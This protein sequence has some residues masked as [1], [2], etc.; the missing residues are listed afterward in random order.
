[1]SRL[2][3]CAWGAKLSAD[4]Y[5]SVLEA[6][7]SAAANYGLT[8]VGPTPF[9]NG[10]D[11]WQLQGNVVHFHR[12]VPTK[13]AEGRPAPNP[14]FVDLYELDFGHFCGASGGARDAEHGIAFDDFVNAR[15]LEFHSP[16]VAE[17]FPSTLDVR[18][19]EQLEAIGVFDGTQSGDRI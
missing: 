1:V 11:G 15:E 16:H 10:L 12:Q 9:G 3:R 6:M 18:P 4:E 13:G 5:R 8:T 7:L 19:I 14:Y 17:G 2:E